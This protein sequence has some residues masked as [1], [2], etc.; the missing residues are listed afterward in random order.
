MKKLAA[1]IIAVAFTAFNSFS[2]EEPDTTKIKIGKKRIVIMDEN[3]EIVDIELDTVDF[4]FDFDEDVDYSSGFSGHWSGLDVG[5]NNFLSPSGT[6]N[7]PATSEY[8]K[9]DAG[10]S[11]GFGL[12][13]AQ[14]S[15]N[16][17]NDQVGF[18]TGLGVELNNYRLADDNTLTHDPTLGYY[19]DTIDFKK[20]NL[21]ASYLNVPLLFEFQVPVSGDHD[22]IHFTFGAIAGIR[23]G[24][25]TKQVYFDGSKKVKDKVN[26]DFHLS[27]FRYGVTARI[28]YEDIHLFANYSLSSLF[29][30]G[31]GPELYPI[32]V[33]L[34]LAMN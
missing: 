24:A 27:T 34:S 28:G 21:F 8:L 4:E 31:E 3:D 20:N 14:K 13:F 33:G 26:D 15:F 29:E 25:H 7:L 6:L 32:T 23:I 9:L 18:V 1:I 11:W 5:L 17:Y 22:A 2:Q 12:N 10:K 30:Q 19:A 16:I